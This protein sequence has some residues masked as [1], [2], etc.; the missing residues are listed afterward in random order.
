MLLKLRSYRDIHDPAPV[1]VFLNE[2]YP[3]FKEERVA[4]LRQIQP[5]LNDEHQTPAAAL[6]Y[7]LGKA[8]VETKTQAPIGSD[9]IPPPPPIPASLLPSRHDSHRSRSSTPPAVFNAFPAKESVRRKRPSH[10]RPT[11]DDMSSGMAAAVSAPCCLCT[12]L[13]LHPAVSAPCCLCTLAPP[14]VC[15]RVGSPFATHGSSTSSR[16]FKPQQLCWTKPAASPAHS[17]KVSG[18]CCL[19]PHFISCGHVRPKWRWW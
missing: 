2:S 15:L 3:I 11:S 7:S 9:V 4:L 14:A 6:L 18:S 19:V 1:D 5:F 13:S 8:P 12:L 10:S 17:A 16:S